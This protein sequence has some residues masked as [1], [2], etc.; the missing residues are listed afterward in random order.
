MSVN[1][2]VEEK[3][4]VDFIKSPLTPVVPIEIHYG[5]NSAL[6]IPASLVGL[7]KGR[8]KRGK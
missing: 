7:L 8:T 1:V 3:V 4:G 5:T 6:L 2:L